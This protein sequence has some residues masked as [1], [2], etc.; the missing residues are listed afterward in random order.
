MR[1]LPGAEPAWVE[2]A[3]HLT[4]QMRAALKRKDPTLDEGGDQV[5]PGQ[6]VRLDE[7]PKSGDGPGSSRR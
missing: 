1:H 5:G 7:H 2:A 4:D 3:A 6:A